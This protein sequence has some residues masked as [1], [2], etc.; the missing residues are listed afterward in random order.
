LLHRTT[1]QVE[2]TELG[3]SYFERCQHIIEQAQ[4]AHEELSQAA[5]SP[6]GLL[7]LSM[8]EEYA[9][10]YIIPHLA[11]FRRLHPGIRFEFDINTRRANL[12][13]DS[14]DIAFRMGQVT[15]SGL[16]ARKLSSF[17]M[18]LYAS[19]TYIKQAPKLK[20][21][22]DLVAHQCLQLSNIDW[23]LNKASQRAVHKFKAPNYSANSMTLL[24]HCVLQDIGIAML[25]EAMV[26]EEVA[27]GLIIRVL[28]EWCPP[29]VPVYALTETRL[30]PA[31]T[32]T[33]LE[34]IAQQHHSK[35][36][37]TSN[38]KIKRTL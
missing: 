2:L 7:R 35:S 1:R 15:D 23:T 19:S 36:F 37:D 8:V 26:R 33:F 28:P 6:S 29:E 38:I 25:S 9:T 32:R 21:P 5:E 14:V 34:F 17:K 31:K 12:V 20:T 10:D 11:K 13:S 27:N 30:L 3:R 22:S 18:G 4:N 16:I 24:K